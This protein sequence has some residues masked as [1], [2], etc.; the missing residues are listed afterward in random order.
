MKEK[1][2]EPDVFPIQGKMPDSREEWR[3]AMALDHLE[4]KYIFHYVIQGGTRV[5]GGQIIDFMVFTKP[6]RT[7]V[8]VQGKYWHSKSRAM[9]D[10]FKNEEIKRL[11]SGQIFDP[12]IIWDYEIPD[13]AHAIRI[14]QER[15]I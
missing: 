9:R 14:L 12:V 11:F 4:Y 1:V 8:Q 6:L 7:P 15:L 13:V 3:V 5:R 2:V 10:H